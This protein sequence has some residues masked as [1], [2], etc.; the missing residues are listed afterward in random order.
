MKGVY[1]IHASRIIR[2]AGLRVLDSHELTIGGADVFDRMQ[3]DKWF[4][5]IS[6]KVEKLR[7]PLR[8]G[9]SSFLREAHMCREEWVRSPK[10]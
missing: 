7:P 3:S 9:A 2:I 10:T 4:H 8:G 5:D 6:P 1:R